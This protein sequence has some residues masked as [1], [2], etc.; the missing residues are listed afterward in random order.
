[1]NTFAR[2]FAAVVATMTSA[3]AAPPGLLL[4]PA[5]DCRQMAATHGAAGFWVGRFTGTYKDLFDDRRPLFAQGCFATEYECR[6]WINEVQSIAIDP[7]LMTCRPGAV[8]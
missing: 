7:G 3:Y 2:V 5:G 1:M 8:Q 4:P 6:R